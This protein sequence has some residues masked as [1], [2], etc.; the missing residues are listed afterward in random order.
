MNA[1][2][3]GEY[4]LIL[5]GREA[6]D[7]DAGQVGLGIAELLGIPSVSLASKIEAEKDL[8]VDRVTATGWETIEVPIRLW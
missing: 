1:I 8:K 4:D 6:A 3:I 7:T 2:K 5:C